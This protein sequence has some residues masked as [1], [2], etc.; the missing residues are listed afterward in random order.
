MELLKQKPTKRP[1]WV[2]LMSEIEEFK[3][4]FG[5]RLKKT[6]CNDRSGPILSTTKVGDNVREKIHPISS[7]EVASTICVS[8]L[9]R[10]RE[11]SPEQRHTERHQEGSEVKA[12]PHERSEQTQSER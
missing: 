9:L 12:R 1:N 11:G 7:K 6:T 10:L 5:G 3:Y 2:D 8:V 4:G